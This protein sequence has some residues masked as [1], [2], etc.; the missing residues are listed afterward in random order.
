MNIVLQN[1][2]SIQVSKVK[3]GLS[4]QF[5]EEIV[6]SIYNRATFIHAR[7]SIEI[8]VSLVEVV[9]GLRYKHADSTV[10]INLV[11]TQLEQ[12]L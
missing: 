1:R 2:L 10:A 11:D 3:S 9:Y 5:S 6:K 4:S 12:D 8:L 7:N